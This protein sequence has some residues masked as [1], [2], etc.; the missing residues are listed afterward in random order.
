MIASLPWPG[1]TL[2]LNGERTQKFRTGE[3]I[4]SGSLEMLMSAN[5]TLGSSLPLMSPA[6]TAEFDC[7]LV[8]KVFSAI[9]EGIGIGMGV[10]N[11]MFAKV[12]VELD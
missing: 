7:Y 10:A 1:P 6:V 2:I 5:L 9:F 12:P 3:E 8:I 11:L 4:V